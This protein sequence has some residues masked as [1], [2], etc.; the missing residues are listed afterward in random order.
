MVGFRGNLSEG[1]IIAEL[2]GRG[3]SAALSE[4]G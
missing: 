2:R 1:A 4:T 3:C